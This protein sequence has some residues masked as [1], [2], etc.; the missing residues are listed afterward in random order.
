MSGRPKIVTEPQ[1]R[2]GLIRR[3]ASP[4]RVPKKPPAS[5]KRPQGEQDA[6]AL[7]TA[8][9]AA[10]ASKPPPRPVANPALEAAK[11][12][13]ASVKAP[14]RSV[15]DPAAEAAKAAAASAKAAEKAAAEAKA[16]EE[17]AIKAE[18]GA[19][20]AK[21]VAAARAKPPAPSEA[22]AFSDLTSTIKERPGESSFLIIIYF[23][24]AVCILCLSLVTSPIYATIGLLPILMVI[25]AMLFIGIIF[26]LMKIP[27][28]TISEVAVSVGT[29]G[30]VTVLCL[31]FIRFFCLNIQPYE[32]FESGSDEP[33]EPKEPA[34]ADL[35][36]AEKAIC[37]LVKRTDGFI[38]AGVGQAGQDNPALVTQAKA[39]AVNDAAIF[40]P[41]T[42]C[43]PGKTLQT[44]ERIDR[45][46][47]SLLKYIEPTLLP[48]CQNATICPKEMTGT[49]IDV[50]NMSLIARL[51]QIQELIKKMHAKYL[52][53]MDQKIKD[54]QSGSVSDSD[55]AAAKANSDANANSDAKAT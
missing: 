47:R 25:A 14:T 38:E 45:M 9:L 15:T 52:D 49:S 29:I 19:A 8:V 6:F 2:S 10:A 11:A 30:L 26:I 44:S 16:A 48:A 23:V 33:K 18:Q 17:A 21:V 32:Q 1:T 31:I 39:K 54:L 51:T 46:E 34:E 53:P 55:K 41:L 20:A 43:P 35:D 22:W 42:V 5:L 37:V 24:G 3:L 36:A 27:G 28:D 40:G 7:P 50:T 4:R 13:A 12:A